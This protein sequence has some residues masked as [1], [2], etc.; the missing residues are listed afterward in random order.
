MRSV[1]PPS[2]LHIASSPLPFNSLP[3]LLAIAAGCGQRWR[4]GCG[5]ALALAL[6]WRRPWL[7]WG[8]TAEA[9]FVAFLAKC[10]MITHIVPC[11]ENAEML[12]F[13]KSTWLH[14]VE[15][16]NASNTFERNNSTGGVAAGVGA[17]TLTSPVGD[18][19][20]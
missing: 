16:L 6:A 18:S 17:G 1:N 4:C 8:E 2:L 20:F 9:T 3:F 14:V 12:L 10:V 5:L 11:Y 13:L 7:G 19:S 15:L